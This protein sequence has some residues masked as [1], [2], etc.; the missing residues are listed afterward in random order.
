M[1]WGVEDHSYAKNLLGLGKERKRD[2]RQQNNR[3]REDF[4]DSY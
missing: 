4:L 2:F 1:K 3:W